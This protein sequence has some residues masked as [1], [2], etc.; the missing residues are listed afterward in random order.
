M[1]ERSR[2]KSKS[3]G[4][5]R[6]QDKRERERGRE[7]DR[8]TGWVGYMLCY[9][10]NPTRSNPSTDG[11]VKIR[12]VLRL[13]ADCKSPPCPEVDLARSLALAI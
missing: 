13:G 6:E 10:M 9:V 7:I 11:R 5:P 1:Q 4:R 12:L 3:R 8:S 2:V